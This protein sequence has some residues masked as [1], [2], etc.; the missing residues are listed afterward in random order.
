MVEAGGD[1]A[2]RE[3]SWDRN[4][5]NAAFDGGFEKGCFCVGYLVGGA[6]MVFQHSCY[7]RLVA[8]VLKL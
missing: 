4:A 6:G 7:W 5:T 2:S 3:K 8:E 1:K